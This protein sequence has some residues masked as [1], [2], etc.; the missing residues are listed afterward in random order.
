[1]CSFNYADSCVNLLPSWT[2]MTFAHE[3]VEL[4]QLQRKALYKYLL[5]LLLVNL[6]CHRIPCEKYEREHLCF[7]IWSRLI[8]TEDIRSQVFT[9]FCFNITLSCDC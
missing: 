8:S 2:R 3:S 6:H 7:N 4:L 1:M 5:L 9:Y